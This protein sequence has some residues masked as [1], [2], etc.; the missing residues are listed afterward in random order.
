MQPQGSATLTGSMSQQG[1]VTELGEVAWKPSKNAYQQNFK[2]IDCK[3]ETVEIHSASGASVI[4]AVTGSG[5]ACTAPDTISVFSAIYFVEQQQLWVRATSDAPA[6]TADISAEVL[7]NGQPQ[8][9]GSVGWKADKGYY[10]QLFRNVTQVPEMLILRTSSGS[11]INSGIDV[12]QS[13]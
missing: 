4:A 7:V 3:P 12:Q 5:N 13:R 9:L 2:N 11:E 10:Q 8:T 6:G 1:Q